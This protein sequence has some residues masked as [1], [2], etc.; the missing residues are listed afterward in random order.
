MA[1]LAADTRLSIASFGNGFIFVTSGPRGAG[2]WESAEKSQL[3]SAS[4]SE[5][6]KWV[7]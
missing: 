5:A 7:I 6:R 4:I 3:L 1:A 2:L